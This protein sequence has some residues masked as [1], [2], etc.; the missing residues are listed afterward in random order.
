MLLSVEQIEK[1]RADIDALADPAS[2][3]YGQLLRWK[4]FL[5]PVWHYGIGLS[6]SHIVDTGGIL[7]PVEKRKGARVLD[8]DDLAFPPAQTIERTKHALTVFS[9]WNYNL[10]GW[11]CEHLGRLIATDQPRCYQSRPLWWLCNLTSEGDHKNAHRIFCDHLRQ[12]D[13]NLLR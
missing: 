2:H 13:P 11:N 4:N 12:V 1:T 5:N 7:R 8:I 6:D 10:L 3:R 9:D